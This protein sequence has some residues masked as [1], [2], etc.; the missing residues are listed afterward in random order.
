MSDA[1]YYADASRQQKG[2]VTAQVIAYLHG[3]G[4][5]HADTLVWHAGLPGW[6]P[7]SRHAATLGIAA[8]PAAATR[9]PTAAPRPPLRAS[10]GSSAWVVA[11]VVL[12]VGI[13]LLGIIAAIA[14]PAYSDYTV[15]AKVA[16]ARMTAMSLKLMVDEHHYSSEQ[17]PE[18]GESGI[19]SAES[20]A[21]DIVSAINVGALEEGG[22]C[23]IQVLF[24]AV[25]GAEPGRELLLARGADGAWRETSNLPNRV[26]PASLRQ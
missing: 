5:L 16:N 10:G 22:D 20:Y 8:Q 26:L 4:E 24:H 15:R 21:D 7:L 1:W 18:N 3:R 12:F 9:A 14:I 25:G 23:A 2:P 17:C 19:G 6:E 13:A 11:I